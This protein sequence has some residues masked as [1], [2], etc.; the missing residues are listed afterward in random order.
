MK[1]GSGEKRKKRKG[2]LRQ[3]PY[4][5]GTVVDHQLDRSSQTRWPDTGEHGPRGRAARAQQQAALVPGD[6]RA[7]PQVG[8]DEP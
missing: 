5:D 8:A 4:P 1:W 3:P 6:Q 2:K 7:S